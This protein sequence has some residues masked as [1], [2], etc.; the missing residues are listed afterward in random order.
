MTVLYPWHNQLDNDF[1]KLKQD[2][3]KQLIVYQQQTLLHQQRLESLLSE[4]KGSLFQ[5]VKKNDGSSAS[6]SSNSAK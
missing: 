6:S 1:E 3:E 4:I 5:Q 2:H